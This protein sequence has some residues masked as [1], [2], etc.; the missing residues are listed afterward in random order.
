MSF[1][2]R[3]V[4]RALMA[5]GRLVEENPLITL[6]WTEEMLELGLSEDELYA[7]CQ[8]TARFLLAKFHSDKQGTAADQRTGSLQVKFSIAFNAL[9]D[10][11]VFTNAMRTFRDDLDE[12]RTVQNADSKT[13]ATLTERVQRAE[14]Q[15]SVALEELK[16][17][18]DR[19]NRYESLFKNWLHTTMYRF[20]GSGQA[21]HTPLAL[22]VQVK[23]VSTLRFDLV[24]RGLTHSQSMRRYVLA[25]DLINEALR[26]KGKGLPC[27]KWNGKGLDLNKAVELLP[28]NDRSLKGGNFANYHNALHVLRGMLSKIQPRVQY[29]S[30]RPVFS[31]VK[32]EGCLARGEWGPFEQ[33]ILGCIFPSDVASGH[34]R[35]GDVKNTFKLK[36]ILPILHPLMVKMGAMVTYPVH[37]SVINVATARPDVALRGFYSRMEESKWNSVHITRIVLDFDF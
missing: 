6:G 25:E 24:Q 1:V 3:E 15:W 8:N 2:S 30:V 19:A 4:R 29:L 16:T 14:L 7:L 31:Q 34:V 12:R 21:T 20:G 32:P 13:V 28:H 5:D 37:D 36:D 35:Q 10:R 23:T 17:A 9:K 26:R 18:S 33:Q 22:P 11:S 27:I